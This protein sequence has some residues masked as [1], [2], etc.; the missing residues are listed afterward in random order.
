MTVVTLLAVLTAIAV[1]AYNTYV[2]RA[3]TAEAPTHLQT[4]VNLELAWI[5]KPRLSDVDGTELYSCWVTSDNRRPTILGNSLPATPSAWGAPNSPLD[6]FD[7]LGFSPAARVY[8]SY[9]LDARTDT[10][11]YV[12]QNSA[13]GYC[14]DGLGVGNNGM[15]NQPLRARAIGDLDGD[16]TSSVEGVDF[17]RI[18]RFVRIIT[19]ANGIPEAGPLLTENPYE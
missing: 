8:Y 2:L 7:I 16:G 14:K 18:A 15:T 11:I 17:G 9:S 10:G 12:K 4:L 3:R 19:A 5:E 1:P 13:D 6:A